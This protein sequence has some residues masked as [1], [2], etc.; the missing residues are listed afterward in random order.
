MGRFVR[1]AWV[2][3]KNWTAIKKLLYFILFF[4]IILFG[5]RKIRYI[6]IEGLGESSSLPNR[7]TA[8]ASLV[9]AGLRHIIYLV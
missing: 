1:W 9:S 2:Y 6:W 7:G 5:I 4:T 3:R 8:K